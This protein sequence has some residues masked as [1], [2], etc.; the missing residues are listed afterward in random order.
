MRDRCVE[1]ALV[2]PGDRLTEE[3]SSGFAYG[4]ENFALAR[5]SVSLQAQ[6][7]S[8]ALETAHYQHEL[9]WGGQ[10]KASSNFTLPLQ[11][12]VQASEQPV[13]ATDLREKL[14]ESAKNCSMAPLRGPVVR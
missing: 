8:R 6:F 4:E 1:A 13:P 5:M 3:M 12:D 9:A 7:V 2:L 11:K 10:S 14:V